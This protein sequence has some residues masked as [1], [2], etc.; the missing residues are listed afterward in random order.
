[1]NDSSLCVSTLIRD[2]QTCLKERDMDAARFLRAGLNESL[3]YGS[4]WLTPEEEA[5]LA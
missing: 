1:M 5:L 4:V 3:Q 2:I